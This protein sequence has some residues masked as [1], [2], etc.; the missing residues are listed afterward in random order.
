MKRQSLGVRRLMRLDTGLE[1]DRN[2]L[3]Y[4]AEMF[5]LPSVNSG[6]PSKVLHQDDQSYDLEWKLLAL[7][8]MESSR[9]NPDS[10]KAAGPQAPS[11]KLEPIAGLF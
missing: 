3:E 6:R 7:W 10:G 5:E 11:T 2:D 9:K 1:P 4:P 8:R